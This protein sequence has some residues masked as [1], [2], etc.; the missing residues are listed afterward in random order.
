MPLIPLAQI[1]PDPENVRRVAASDAAAADLRASMAAVGLIQ[2]IVVRPVGV[3]AADRYVI[4]AGHR[5]FAAA[6]ALG[7]TEIEATVREAPDDLATMLQLVENTARADMVPIDQYEAITRLTGHGY[8][9]AAIAAALNITER[10]VD[11]LATIGAMH[12]DLVAA[13]R[14]DPED[15]PEERYLR[16]ICQ[17]SAA[18]QKAALDAMNEK[19]GKDRWGW[20][21]LAQALTVKRIPMSRA[22]FVVAA[23]GLTVAGDLFEDPAATFTTDVA[24]FFE[25]QKAWLME[26][27]RRREQEG[28]HAYV[29][30]IEG[31]KLTLPKGV[32]P[33]DTR[34]IADFKCAKPKRK[35]WAWIGAVAADG[36][37]REGFHAVKQKAEKGA[38]PAEPQAAAAPQAELASRL[39]KKGVELI[40][41]RKRAAAAEAAGKLGFDC[42]R[43]RVV[44]LSL[45]LA[46][47]VHVEGDLPYQPYGTIDLLA[48]ADW[49][50]FAD[51]VLA[52]ALLDNSDLR[53]VEVIGEFIGGRA[54]L[55]TDDEHLSVLRK[56]ALL[57]V[58]AAAGQTASVTGTQAA[59]R[60]AI[61]KLRP[62][63]TKRELPELDW[64]LTPPRAEEP[65]EDDEAP[66]DDIDELGP[67]HADMDLQDKAA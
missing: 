50:M 39:T 59:M 18:D 36:E 46:K 33:Y 25:A 15:F 34:G 58:L 66:I 48:D 29:C 63:L 14:A 26:E 4:I 37:V 44:A 16:V 45:L 57:S 30:E 40:E 7:W 60:S 5:R 28:F 22:R 49:R 62:E 12:P 20:Y 8:S 41:K 65:D 2:P 13:L 1:E 6:M 55:P 42:D 67:E 24:G 64:Q 54:S 56:P 43:L 9:T 38:A 11:Q 61:R 31:Y 3:L 27:R 23:S 47:F 51:S 32:D 35:E 21:D 52:G 19:H 53:D 10:R 17:R